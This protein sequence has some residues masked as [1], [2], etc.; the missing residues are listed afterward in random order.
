MQKKAGR[1]LSAETA[2]TPQN[3]SSKNN[4]SLRVEARR[5]TTCLASGRRH[6]RDGNIRATAA[7]WDWVTA[8]LGRYSS[9]GD[10]AAG[11]ARRPGT[12]S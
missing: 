11:R 1:T 9:A 6:G 7:G 3:K 4:G 10:A 2:V 12:E 8:S 5:L